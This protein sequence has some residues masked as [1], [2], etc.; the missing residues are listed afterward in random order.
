M[1]CRSIIIK[2]CLA[3]ADRVTEGRCNDCWGEGARDCSWH[4][5]CKEDNLRERQPVAELI[6]LASPYSHPDPAMRE[7]RY[8]QACEVAALL[9]RDGH[10]QPHCSLSPA[11]SIR[12]AGGLGLLAAV[13]R[14]DAPALRCPGGVAAAG[15]GAE[16]RSAGRVSPGK[17][18]GPKDRP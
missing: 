4:R 12:L 10:L 2:Y 9:M 11:D 18:V 16:R 8:K 3:L 15:V 14:G 7:L 13:R 1:A 5:K 6:Y 17:G